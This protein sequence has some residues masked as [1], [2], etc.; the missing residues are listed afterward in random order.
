MDITKSDPE[1]LKRFTYNWK[2]FKAR[3]FN[4]RQKPKTNFP[5]FT[6]CVPLCN[7]SPHSNNVMYSSPQA[8]LPGNNGNQTANPLICNNVLHTTHYLSFLQ[9]SIHDHS[10]P[11]STHSTI[12]LPHPAHNVYYSCSSSVH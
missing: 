12:S 6:Q 5:S 10:P 3:S 11:L 7:F 9:L 4:K 2:S 1:K 8:L